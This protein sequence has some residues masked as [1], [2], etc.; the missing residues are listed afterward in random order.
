MGL[1]KI[2]ALVAVLAA[3]SQVAAHG[4][5]SDV[6]INGVK[7]KNY[8]PTS[9][10]Y[11]APAN[12]PIRAGWT[13]EQ[14][15]LGFVAPNAYGTPNIICHR[16]ATP[17]KGHIRVAAGDV[18]TLQWNTWPESHK[19]PVFDHLA[20]CNG[21]CESVNKNDLRF[22]KIDG[23]GLTTAPSTYAGDLLIQNKNQWSVRIPT[24]IAPGNYVLRHEILAL[25]SAAQAN[26]AQSYPQCINLE[27]TGSGT[28]KPAGTAGIS[29]LS[30]TE[31]GV[32]WNVWVPAASYPI[33]GGP[34]V[35]GGVSQIPQSAVTATATGTVTPA[36][37]SG[38]A[39][40]VAPPTVPPPVTTTA[41]AP[42]TLRT[43]TVVAPPPQTTQP[44]NG[45][46]APVWG[47]CGGQG[48]T[49]PTA[50]T[51]GNRCNVQNAFY[52]QCVPN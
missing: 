30:S 21:P 47:Q 19:G 20:N 41:A 44:S 38:P 26:G 1:S 49:G 42:T 35:E 12:R 46:T 23:A 40:T 2:G 4:F 27:I 18:V 22:F 5:V 25:H 36:G 48:W 11:Q 14:E 28:S 37:Q 50:C 51:A 43:T 45:A 34:I 32:N 16:Q 3:A 6:I 13:A 17:G 52:S 7:Y 15:D 39:P 33:P 31:A 10:W 9:D 8:D 29:L 24:N